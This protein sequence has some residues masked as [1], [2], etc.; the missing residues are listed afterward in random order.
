MGNNFRNFKIEIRSIIF[1]NAVKSFNNK[2]TMQAQKKN[3]DIILQFG[4][5]HLTISFLL[6]TA[7]ID[8]TL[9]LLGRL[10]AVRDVHSGLYTVQGY[11][12]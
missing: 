5:L 4:L 2:I 1:I 11:N 10:R 9:T 6:L 7:K 3:Y 8:L 12:C